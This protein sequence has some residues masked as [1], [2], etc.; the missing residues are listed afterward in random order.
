MLAAVVGSWI[1]GTLKRASLQPLAFVSEVNWLVIVGPVLATLALLFVVVLIFH[2]RSERHRFGR[3]PK[4][5][6]KAASR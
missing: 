4:R 6:P 5:R 1:Y 3:M 2:G